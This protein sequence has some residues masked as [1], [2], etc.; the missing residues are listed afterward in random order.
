MISGFGAPP[1]GILSCGYVYRTCS[2]LREALATMHHAAAL[3]RTDMATHGGQKT[4]QYIKQASEI[5]RAPCH[6]HVLS[7]ALRFLAHMSITQGH[8]FQAVV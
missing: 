8:K 1:E 2:W 5:W 6:R 4:I 3:L 7:E